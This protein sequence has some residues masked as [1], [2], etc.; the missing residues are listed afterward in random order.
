VT[1]R[2]MRAPTRVD[3]DRWAPALDAIRRARAAVEEAQSRL[4]DALVACD[5]DAETEAAMAYLQDRLDRAALALVVQPP[6]EEHWAGGDVEHHVTSL[7][8]SHEV[9]M[10]LVPNPSRQTKGAPEG[11]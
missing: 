6:V 3:L 7:H 9:R 4:V 1:A 2:I 5:A 8:W 11:E 10:S